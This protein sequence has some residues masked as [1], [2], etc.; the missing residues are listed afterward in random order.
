MNQEEFIN[1][2]MEEVMAK[3]ST[4][5]PKL[6]S[7]PATH[8]VSASDAS[9]PT[10]VSVANY[11]LADKMPELI[12]SSTGKA[13]SELTL[14]KV[15]SGELKPEDFRISAETLELQAQVAES[16]NRPQ[17]AMNMRRAAELSKVPDDELLAAYD[18][19]RP[20]RKSKAELLELADRL[21]KKYGCV[22]SANFIREAAEVYEQRGTLRRDED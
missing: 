9:A 12:R 21:E 2:L 17:L 13:L 8:P 1:K 22:I 11:P 14:E 19:L 7:K 10:K 6:Q 3:L 5:A 18:A 15:L 16:A 20:Y 4:D